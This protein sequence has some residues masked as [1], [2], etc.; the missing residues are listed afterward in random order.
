[1]L[2]GCGS[3]GRTAVFTVDTERLEEAREVRRHLTDYR[4]DIEWGVQGYEGE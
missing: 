1:M 3:G 2:A 4:S